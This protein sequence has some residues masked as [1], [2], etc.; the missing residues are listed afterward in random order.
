VA[1]PKLPLSPNSQYDPTPNLKNQLR[2]PGP[3]LPH[4]HRSRY[5][6][7]CNMRSGGITSK[8]PS[9]A[10]DAERS[11]VSWAPSPI[12]LGSV[13]RS[14]YK[15]K[16]GLS[17]PDIFSHGVARLKSPREPTTPPKSSSSARETYRYF[18]VIPPAPL[19]LLHPKYIAFLARYTTCNLF[20]VYGIITSKKRILII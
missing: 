17:Q 19:S 3:N 4:F 13:P 16:E 11:V 7:S 14:P 20:A 18:Q 10:R 6:V 2:P 12:C 8:Y 9:S 5:E 1:V 15:V